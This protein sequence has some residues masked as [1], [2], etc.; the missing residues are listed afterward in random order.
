MLN[1]SRKQKHSYR[2]SYAYEV[3]SSVDP[4]IEDVGQWEDELQ[5]TSLYHLLFTCFTANDLPF[6]FQNYL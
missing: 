4:D 6:R 5:G 2:L 3:G 1:T